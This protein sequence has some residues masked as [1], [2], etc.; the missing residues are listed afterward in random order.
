VSGIP[1]PPVVADAVAKAAGAALGAFLRT[2]VGMI[3][4]GIG[5]AIGCF[6]YAAQGATWRGFAAAAIALAAAATMGLVLAGKRA[7]I[8]GVKTVVAKS[9]AGD[10]VVGVVFDRLAALPG[11]SAVEKLPLAQAEV[12]L[13]EALTGFFKGSE[14][15][16]VRRKLEEKLVEIVRK[17]TLARFREA[18]AREGG[19]DLNVVRA[20]LAARADLAIGDTAEA[21]GKKTTTIFVV[22]ISVVACLAAVGLRQI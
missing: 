8:A 6:W 19:I 14:S 15:G 9:K 13:T 22:A 10:K 11:V 2:T 3:T 7:A 20:D 4:L 12:C 16:F 17:L 1:I 21:M 5:L 18:D